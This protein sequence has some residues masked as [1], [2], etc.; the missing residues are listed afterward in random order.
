MES[1]KL[2]LYGNLIMILHMTFS[3]GENTTDKSEIENDIYLNRLPNHTVSK[4]YSIELT[5]DPEEDIFN[6][7]CNIDIIIYNATRTIRLHSVNLNITQ[8][9]L[10]QIIDVYKVEYGTHN[11]LYLDELQSAVLNF[12]FLIIPGNHTLSLTYKGIIADNTEGFVKLSYKNVKG[13]NKWLIA[14]NNLATGTPS[15]F[16]CWD[17]PEIKT[18]FNITIKNYKHYRTISNMPS[19]SICPKK[20]ENLTAIYFDT[21]FESICRIAIVL[22]DMDDYSDINSKKRYLNLWGRKP[23]IQKQTFAFELIENLTY[24]IEDTCKLQRNTTMRNHFVIPGLQDNGLKNFHFV[25]YR[26]EDVIYNEEIDLIERRIEISR[27]IGRKIM[28]KL[29]DNVGPSWSYLWLHEAITTLFGLYMINETMPD[30]RLLDLFVVQTQQESLRLDDGQIMKPLT[31]ELNDNIE[32]NSFFSLARYLKAPCILRMLHHAVGNKIFQKAIILFFKRQLNSLDEFWNAMQSISNLETIYLEGINMKDVMDPWIEEEQYPIL[33]TEALSIGTQR[34]FVIKNS[35]KKWKVIPL[36][37]TMPPYNDFMDTIPWYWLEATRFERIPKI[38]LQ[39]M[40]I[41]VNIQQSGYYRVNSCRDN[42]LR[43][44]SYLNS[45]NYTKIHVLNRAQIIDDAFHFVTSGK[46]EPLIFWELAKYLHQ[47]TDYI[48]WYP[49]FK[50]I[51]RMSYIIPLRTNDSLKD[52]GS[53][54]SKIGYEEH[55]NDTYFIQC[56]RQEAARWACVLGSEECKK[57]AKH[58][59]E[60]HLTNQM[61]NTLLPWWRK[62]I[63]C[64]GLSVNGTNNMDIFDVDDALRADPEILEALACSNKISNIVF[65]LSRMKVYRTDLFYRIFLRKKDYN[66]CNKM[67]CIENVFRNHI[68]LFYYVIQKHANDDLFIYIR[69]SWKEIIPEKMSEAAAL[70]SI[71]NNINSVRRIAQISEWTRNSILYS[72]VEEKIRMRSSEINKH[73]N[74]FKYDQ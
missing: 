57:M 44:A 16:P 21:N 67:L 9:T 6:G 42:W 20:N 36:T 28:D 54:S 62:W 43:I 69:N 29:F 35:S 59:L 52:I 70:V 47:E 63:Y 40:W 60:Q 14:I 55:S 23:I 33:E 71:L 17:D 39:N 74:S 61:H 72:E 27:L 68:R 51:E 15:L 22:L 26:E 25:F 50:A 65:F 11:V 56:L 5:L 32:I 49:M 46:L 66:V 24:I 13:D 48:A 18:K 19:T 38:Q 53:A 7:I 64:N 30:I 2:L 4:Q 73:I 58:K 3:A 41:I 8:A 34:T 10:Y 31:S 45:K 37:Y 1:I 12:H